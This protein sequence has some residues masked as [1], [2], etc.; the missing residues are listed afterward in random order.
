MVNVILLLDLLECLFSL[1]AGAVYN[2]TGLK[3]F[4][5]LGSGFSYVYNKPNGLIVRLRFFVEHSE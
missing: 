5:N 2:T 1:I 3:W 4:N